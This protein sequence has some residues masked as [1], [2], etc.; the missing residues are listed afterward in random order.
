MHGERTY[1]APSYCGKDCQTAHWPAHKTDCNNA[2][3]RKQL[4]RTG[5]VA[6]E[7]FEYSRRKGFAMKLS[8]VYRKGSCLY[9][10][11]ARDIMNVVVDFPRHLFSSSKDASAILAAGWCKSSAA[12][13][14]LIISSMLQGRPVLFSRIRQKADLK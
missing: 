4:Y 6:Q 12:R 13:M 2:K 8:E 3:Y 5:K 9:V 11:S 10:R 1:A 7:I 14:S